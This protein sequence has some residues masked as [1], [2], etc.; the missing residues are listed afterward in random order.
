MISTGAKSI[1]KSIRQLEHAI[2]ILM[3]ERFINGIRV[4]PKVQNIVATTKIKSKID[5]HSVASS[6]PKL[7]FEPEPIITLLNSHETFWWV[8]FWVVDVMPKSSITFIIVSIGDIIIANC[9]HSGVLISLTRF[10]S[11]ESNIFT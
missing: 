3:R 11:I 7:T 6:L 4:E 8:S 2:D 9:C 5:L 1:S 10:I